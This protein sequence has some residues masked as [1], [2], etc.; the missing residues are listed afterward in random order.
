[1]KDL[2]LVLR[3]KFASTEADKAIAKQGTAL[4]STQTTMDRLNKSASKGL[5]EQEHL[6]QRLGTAVGRFGHGALEVFDR[7]IGRVNSLQRTMEGAAKKVLSLRNVVMGSAVGAGIVGLTAHALKAGAGDVRNARKL[8]REFGKGTL[9]SNSVLAQSKSISAA[10]GIEDDDALVGLLPIARAIRE[11]KVGDSVGGK[12]IR[13]KQ[14]LEAVQ[15]AQFETASARFKQLAVLQPDMSPEQI[16]FLLA[17]AG[18]GEEGLRGLGKALNLGKASMAD[19]MRDAKK[20]KSGVGDTVGAMFTRA[21]FTDE[22]VK[23]EQGSFEFQTKQLG[24][25]IETSFGDIGAKAIEKLNER[26]G[27]GKS[28]ADRWGEV[29]EKNKDTIDK[30]ANGL[31]KMIEKAM[32]LAEKLP[33][34]FKWIEE[35]KTT[36]LTVASAY[37]GLKVVGGVRSLIGNA[38]GGAGKV[39]DAL[40]AGEGQKVFVTNWPGGGV[41]GAG[42]PGGAPGA[43][44]KLGFLQKAGMVAAAGTA[45]YALGTALDEMS[46]GRIS[47]GIADTMGD[48]LGQRETMKMEENTGVLAHAGRLQ[49]AATDRRHRIQQMEMAGVGHGAAVYAADHADTEVGQATMKKAGITI[50]ISI[51]QIMTGLGQTPAQVAKGLMPDLLEQITRALTQQNPTKP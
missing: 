13:N 12:K 28:L 32:D 15:K 48:K 40:G 43:A 23:T 50:P 27:A 38:T 1:M 19:V 49:Q 21:G 20:S 7:T 6:W 45:G 37:A 11:T 4:K 34:A 47:G 24:T 14:Q 22:A 51:G 10:A 41:G 44:G 8:D 33:S 29:M 30:L 31:A 16:G 2:S 46:G 18:Q 36:L 3:P 17:E 25:A 26:L 35:H 39:L 9:L 42:G 5:K